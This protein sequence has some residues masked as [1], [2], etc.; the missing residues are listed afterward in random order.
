[1]GNIPRPEIGTPR[2]WFF[3]DA[4]EFP[5]DNGAHVWI[6]DLPGQHVV[7]VAVVLDLPASCEPSR[8]EGLGMIVA[9]TSDEGTLQ[10]PGHQLA[11][12]VESLGAVYGASARMSSTIVQLEVP[13]AKLAPA[14]DL[15]AEIIWNPAHEACD[16]ERHLAL[17]TAEIDQARIHPGSLVQLGL[18]R[19]LLASATRIGRPLGGLPETVRA[20]TREEVIR[21]HQ[22]WWRPDGATIIVA[23]S[24]PPN[25]DDLVA[26]SFAGWEPGGRRALHQL[27]QP[28]TPRPHAIVIDRPEAVQADIRIGAPGPDRH[29]PDW[30]ALEVAACALGGSFSSRLNTVLRE[31]KGYTYGAHASFHPYRNRGSFVIQTSCRTEVTA[32]VVTEALRIADLTAAPLTS[33]EIIDARN[34]LLGIAPLHFATA[35]AIAGQSAD[36]ASAGLPTLWLN[37]HQ[38]RVAA[39][40]AD[41]ATESFTKVI[42]SGQLTTVICGDAEQLVPALTAKG[43][44]PVVWSSEKLF[45]FP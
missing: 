5:L 3:P 41:A 2:G 45:E 39:V 37:S 34:Y 9:R 22:R 1:M 17:R 12:A 8:M 35:G 43:L 28:A 25:I 24:L 13:S 26:A 33:T 11:E 42:D 30:A 40:D 23:G 4:H 7:S 38:Q 21:Y 16:I 19:A 44:A 32:D 14:L 6:H 36:M 10:Y 29:D 31:E 20:I 15:L 27:T 18:Q